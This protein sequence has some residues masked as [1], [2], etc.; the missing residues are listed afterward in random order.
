MLQSQLLKLLSGLK[1][2]LFILSFGYSGIYRNSYLL[3]F[4]GT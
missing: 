3:E 2:K 4:A 1:I